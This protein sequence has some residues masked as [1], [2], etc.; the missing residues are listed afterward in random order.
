MVERAASVWA[1]ILTPGVIRSLLLAAALLVSPLG[2]E[3]SPPAS[4]RAAPPAPAALTTPEPARVQPI[5]PAP[6]AAASTAIP[7]AEIATRA[8]QVPA[9]IRALTAPIAPNEELDA[10]RARLPELRQQMDLEL[11]AVDTILR[12]LPTLDMIQSQQ[13]LW[14]QRELRASSWLTLLT[15]RATLLQQAL[16]GLSALETTWRQTRVEATAGGVPAPVIV[17]VDGALDAIRSA[18]EPLSEQRTAVLDLQSLV[19]EQVARCGAVQARLREAQQ[20]AMGGLLTRVG[21]PVWDA[22]GWANARAALTDRAGN[23]LARWDEITAYVR[24]PSSGLLLHA[25]IFVLLAGVFVAGRRSVR[26]QGAGE[27]HGPSEVMAFDRPYA[28]ALVVTLLIAT[29]PNAA[30]PPILRSLLEVVALVP[31]IRVTRPALDS[32]LVPGVYTLAILFALDSVRQIFGGVPLIEPAILTV[33]MTVGIAVLAYALLGGELRRSSLAAAE[34]D[35]LHGLRVGATLV[36]ALFGIAL[37]GSAV[38]YLR[39]ARLL[40]G[41][42]LASGALALTLFAMARVGGGTVAFVLRAWPFRL[43][44]MVQHHRDFLERR[45]N[46]LMIWA[47]VGGWAIRTL[48][49]VGLLQPVIT[50][51]SALLSAQLGRGS[52]TFSLGDVLE[53]VVTIW[54]AYVVSSVIRF[55]LQ[56]DVYPRTGLTRGMTYALSS[57]LN[58]IILTLG[59]L[60]ALGAVGMDLTKMTVLAGAFGVGLGFG[61]QAIVNNFVSGLILLFERPIHVGDVIEIGDLVGEVSRIGIR[62][63]VVRTYRGA[64]IIVPNGQLA[65]ERVVNWTLSDRRRRIELPVGVAYGSAP[66]KVVEVLESVARGHPSILKEPA[67]QA[68]FIK[69]DDSSINFELRAWTAQFE[70]WPKIQTDLASGVYAALQAAG[71][72]IPFPQREI[73]VLNDGVERAP[74]VTAGAGQAPGRTP[75]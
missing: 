28:S 15:H 14:A 1:T 38:G 2:G 21:R 64:E 34:T 27:D 52:I 22:R 31:A 16:N 41:G 42:L 61:M 39:L 4:P 5:P 72:S 54:L 53:F 33:E 70:R 43:F 69:F 75:S 35:R 13:Q 9:L 67:P 20:H 17:Q 63:S 48:A 68:I 37:A 62:A 32:R 25:I 40:S 23:T 56:E 24:D 73:R 47:A 46:R 3:T 11:L 51:G 58:Y 6:A 66:D 19:A 71:M 18:E 8:A 60:L 12:N 57:L 55:V 59:F 45:A 29:R 10:I 50:T 30:V 49:Y 65:T 44:R 74:N 7:V 26:R 36:L